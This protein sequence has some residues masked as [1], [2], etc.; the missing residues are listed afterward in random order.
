MKMSA[1]TVIIFTLNAYSTFGDAF[2]DDIDQDNK[3]PL[4]QNYS[5]YDSLIL[6]NDN[7]N[8]YLEALEAG[9]Q[10]LVL[11]K[12]NQDE[13][14]EWYY[15]LKLAKYYYLTGQTDDALRH[16]RLYALLNT[17]EM[18][19]EKDSQMLE[20]E[21]AYL[22][23]INSLMLEMNM[24]KTLIKNLQIEN[25]RYYQGQRTIQNAIKIGFGALF[26][27]LVIIVYNRFR[28]KKNIETTQRQEV[29]DLRR[30]NDHV[31]KQDMELKRNNNE[32]A[33]IKEVQQHNLSYARNIQL[34]L[35]PTNLDLSKMLGDS[36]VLHLP[37]DIISGDFYVVHVNGDKTVLAVFDCPG[38]GVNAAHS[39]VITHNLF[40]EIVSQGITAPSMILTMMD[41]NLKY[42]TQQ[43]EPRKEMIS[44][45]K[46]AVCTINS[47]TKEV[48]YAGAHFPLFYIHLDELHFVRGNRFPVGDPL[49]SDKFYSSSNLRLSTGD[50]IYISSDGYYS[51]LGG[52]KNKKFL[53]SSLINLI[54]T[55]FSQEIK[56]QQ[57]ILEKVF[58]EWK[59]HGEQTDDILVLGIRL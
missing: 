49:F 22:E 57:F 43:L 38:H 28:S 33:R 39:T 29:E 59:S 12:K 35:L 34:S 47:E 10:G 36:F 42:E 11:S 41:Q 13:K 19:F 18:E 24:D 21:E 46:M 40:K 48:E 5:Y 23:E 4:S 52:K 20:L 14:K 26:L 2:Q 58:Q 7:L 16:F 6:V 51:Q 54:K 53:R 32:L 44:G 31:E 30:L 17:S 25:E 3:I 1:L 27:I 50:F 56:E 37:R 8:N 45:V 15:H 55:I 9:K